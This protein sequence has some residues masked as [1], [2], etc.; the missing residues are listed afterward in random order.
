MGIT[1]FGFLR[2]AF[3]AAVGAGCGF[4]TFGRAHPGVEERDAP[5]T[6]GFLGDFL[7]VLVVVL[8]LLLVVVVVMAVG[9]GGGGWLRGL[10]RAGCG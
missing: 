2:A 3:G 7:V 6:R 1:E 4:V 9:G 8:V 10:W 5:A